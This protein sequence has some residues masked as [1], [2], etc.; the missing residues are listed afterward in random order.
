VIRRRKRKK[1][2]AAQATQ[3]PYARFLLR[4]PGAGFWLELGLIPGSAAAL[5][6]AGIYTLEQL[7]TLSREDF[8]SIRGVS[9]RTLAICEQALGRPLRSRIQY[10]TDRGLVRLAS[11]VLL[12]AGIESVEQ[13]REMKREDVLKL[14][15]MGETLLAGIEEALGFRLSPTQTLG[16]WL[17]KG[18]YRKTAAAL[19][20]AGILNLAQLAKRR[21]E[22][23]KLGLNALELRMVEVVLG[24]VKAS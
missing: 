15:G 17:A 10:W 12:R 7:S 21:G 2:T 19:V 1:A 3:V 13:L 5:C 14:N 9:L 6:N 18:F 23:R 11:G 8:I 22:L 20:R 24:G 16:D 4:N